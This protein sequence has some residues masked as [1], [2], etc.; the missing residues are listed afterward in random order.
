MCAPSHDVSGI[1]QSV[2]AASVVRQSSGCQGLGGTGAGGMEDR[3]TG[4][5]DMRD[6][7]ALGRGTGEAGGAHRSPG[8]PG[9]PH[10]A[11]LQK[12]ARQR[13][14][15]NEERLKEYSRREQQKSPWENPELWGPSLPDGCVHVTSVLNDVLES[16]LFLLVCTQS[17]CLAGP[18]G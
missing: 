2:Q 4:V 7:G 15:R 3:G 5:G 8:S 10:Q 6:R 17:L 14:W 1:G 16:Y 13:F 11:A 18:A 12:P 9:T